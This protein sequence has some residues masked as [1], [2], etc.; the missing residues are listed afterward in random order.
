MNLRAAGLA[1]LV[2]LALAGCSTPGNNRPNAT[3]EQIA[4]VAYRHDGPPAITLF[5]M[6]SNSTNEGAHSSIMINA[7]SQ[8]II[9]DPAGSVRADYITEADD[10]IYGVTPTF[11]SFYERAHARE[12]YRVRIQRVEVPAA[13]AE[14]AQRLAMTSGSARQSMCAKS[15]SS[16][17][18]QLPGFDSV[19]PTWF[20]KKLAAQMSQLPGVTD[21]ILRETDDD[22]KSL[23]LALH[24]QHLA[25]T[26]SATGT[27]TGPETGQGAGEGTQR[28][29]VSQ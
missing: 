16:I 6:I 29:V 5:T 19:S 27:E 18:A 10:V 26:A 14:Q 28:A 21:R 4:A 11:E 13:V 7:P 22:D 17:L 3:A 23:A 20:P 15:T 8:R 1:T 9:Y 24:R 12:T 25:R 2:A